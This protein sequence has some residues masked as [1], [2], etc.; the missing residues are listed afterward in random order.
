[1]A[2]LRAPGTGVAGHVV[3]TSELPGGYGLSIARGTARA[4]LALQP[5]LALLAFCCFDT[6]SRYA[7]VLPLRPTWYCRS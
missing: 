3:M 4:L 7:V 5:L 6:G 1:V 2:P